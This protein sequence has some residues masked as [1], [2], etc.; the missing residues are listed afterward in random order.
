MP[1]FVALV[2]SPKTGT[3]NVTAIVEQFASAAAFQKATG[4]SPAGLV[5][6]ETAAGYPTRAAAQKA[7]DAYNKSG[8]GKAATG[9][10]PYNDYV[11]AGTPG[12]SN[13][14]KGIDAI[15][16]FFNKLGDRNLWIRVGK[17][18]IGGLLLVIGLVH[19]TGAGGAVAG[20]ARKVP[21]PI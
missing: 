6:G 9:A 5:P 10:A 16:A 20:L 14:L 21:V 15:G 17:V 19:I 7:A 18:V 3:G 12:P 8:A 11:G 1:W 4:S 13:P 2:T